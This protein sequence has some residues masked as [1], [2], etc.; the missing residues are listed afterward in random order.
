MSQNT[1]THPSNTLS[2]KIAGMTC[3]SCVR[4]VERVLARVPGVEQ[5]SVNLATEQ[6]RLES[7]GPLD[8][9]AVAQAVEKAGYQAS[10]PAPPEAR[11]DAEAAGSGGKAVL[12]AALL[13]LPLLA[14]MLLELAG[15]HWM[16]DGWLQL[17]L[18]TPVQFWLGA[19]FYRAGWKAALDLSGN[20]DLLVALGTSA[21]YGLSLWQLL[22]RGGAMPHLYFEAS[23]VVIT[24]VL[25]GKWLEARA[26]RQTAS[27]IRALQALRPDTARV[28]RAGLDVDVAL[29]Q[30][31]VGELVV[32]RPGE[33][34]ATD[35]VIE[36]GA[37]HV[38]ESL[39]TGESLPVAR[40]PGGRVTG[41]AINGE[42]QLLVRVSAVGAESTLARIIRLVEDAQAAKAPVQ[43]LV[44]KVS[45][46]FVPV[47]LVLALL[48]LG[49]WWLVSGDAERAI[50]NAVAVLV[51]AC[52][53]ALGL[54][55]PA[56]I[57][58]GTGVAARHGILIKDAEALEL[59]HRVTT[60][61]FDKTGTLTEGKPSLAALVP[62]GIG[63]QR[64]LQLAAAIQR[65]SEH[66]L[67][68][69]VL[70]A[71]TRA[72][73]SAAEGTPVAPAA[74]DAAPVASEVKALPG[75]GVGALVDGRRLV[76]GSTRL[77]AEQGVD[78]APLSARAAEL[79]AQGLTISWLAAEQPPQLLGLLAFGDRLKPQARAAVQALRT[80]HIRTVLLTGDNAGSA[81]AV[82]AALGMDQVVANMLPADKAARVAALRQDGERV[83]MVGDGINDA[84]ALA[85]ADVGVAMSSGT[86]VAMHAAG[87]TLMRGDPALVA[88]AID[89]SRR[90]YAKIR[91]NL[92]WAFIYNLVGIPLAAL[93]LLN[94]MVAGAAMALSSVSVISNA[95]LLRRWRPATGKE[96]R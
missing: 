23:A 87:I 34:I 67:A 65:G 46:V 60:V 2:V 35:G 49:G 32:V 85:A 28:R 68:R 19:R 78:T 41:G 40:Q 50:I 12:L 81:A 71:A 59:A 70:E 8:F 39:I 9:A 25:L 52:P 56:A 62:A 69:A 38:D 79:E 21:A 7:S 4:R 80:R 58:A 45:A 72:A 43:Q 91:Q 47:V 61:V 64:L 15:V 11:P 48:T 18:A 26:K 14:P 1:V 10:L 93:G 55:T 27:A 75:R 53:C 77:M 22:A 83:A 16:L 57:M 20:M 82:G 94:P 24:L 51:I 96:D 90:S 74:Q 31:R 36:E 76:L 84:P 42:G 73:P 89:I 63:E 33:R 30:V 95:L 5:V 17:L 29:A 13:S 92:F 54:A 6:A 3:A 37:S 66:A 44:D 86:D 88:A